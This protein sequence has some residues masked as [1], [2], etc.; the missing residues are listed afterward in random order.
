[1]NTQSCVSIRC[2]LFPISRKKTT[3][4]RKNELSG[5]EDVPENGCKTNSTT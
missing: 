2:I 1:M 4:K 5:F 3:P